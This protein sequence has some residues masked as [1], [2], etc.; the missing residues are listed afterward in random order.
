[1]TVALSTDGDRTYVPDR[2]NIVA[3]GPGRLRLSVAFQAR[4]GKIHV[5]YTSERR[6]VVNHAIFDEDWVEGR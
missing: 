6:T 2:R 5:V 1:M 3:E 4:D